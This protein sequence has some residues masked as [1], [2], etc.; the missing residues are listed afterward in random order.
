MTDPELPSSAIEIEALLRQ[1]A[2]GP[3]PAGDLNPWAFLLRLP[4]ALLAER[5]W[6]VVDQ[7]LVDDDPRVRLCALE[8]LMTWRGGT[9]QTLPR[10]VDLAEHHADRFADQEVAGVRLRER[11]Q[12]AIANQVRAPGRDSAQL[13][14]LLRQLEDDKLSS[15]STATVFGALD[16]EYLTKRVSGLDDSAEAAAYRQN[17]AAAVALYQRDRLPLLL[18]AL[19]S[20]PAAE[21]E[22][23]LAAVLPNLVLDEDKVVRIALKNR[24]PPPRAPA[25]SEADCRAALGL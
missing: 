6:P 12:H 21:K 20:R 18:R 5:V 2:A 1:Q 15:A 9:D 8:F 23:V 4:D 3:P 25:P 19:A 22:Q 17:G 13:L 7:L 14:A 11:L 24:L 16:P 10:L